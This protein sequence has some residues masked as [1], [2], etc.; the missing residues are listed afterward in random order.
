MSGGGGGG[1]G[2]P[3]SET[4][5]PPLVSFLADVLVPFESEE[6][7]LAYVNHQKYGI[8]RQ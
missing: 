6:D 8:H 4:P 1:G 5:Q 7:L 2:M 3:P